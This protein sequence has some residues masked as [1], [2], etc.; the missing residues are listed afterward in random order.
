MVSWISLFVAP[1]FITVEHAKKKEEKKKVWIDFAGEGAQ[2]RLRFWLCHFGMNDCCWLRHFFFFAAD[3]HYCDLNVCLFWQN[4]ID[5]LFSPISCCKTENECTGDR[6]QQEW[7]FVIECSLLKY[8]KIN[9]PPHR[10]DLRIANRNKKAGMWSTKRIVWKSNYFLYSL[11][12]IFIVIY[13][14]NIA[15][16]KFIDNQ[17]VNIL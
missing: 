16:I 14:S 7:M 4:E 8:N 13:H 11:E 3:V 15:R 17:D 2:Y 6:F 9:K 12:S 1:L 5:Y 10:N